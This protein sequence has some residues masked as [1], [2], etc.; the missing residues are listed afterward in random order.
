MN[1]LSFDDKMLELINWIFARHE[2]HLP[3]STILLLHEHEED[4]RQFSR[5]TDIFGIR[6]RLGYYPEGSLLAD[7]AI[8]LLEVLNRKH[9]QESFWRNKE[10]EMLYLMAFGHNDVVCRNLLATKYYCG[11]TSQTFEKAS[12]YGHMPTIEIMLSKFNGYEDLVRNLHWGLKGAI[13]GKQIKVLRLYLNLGAEV[14]KDHISRALEFK[15]NV[16]IFRHLIDF[17]L[18][19]KLIHKTIIIAAGCLEGL[20]K[21]YCLTFF[22][23]LF[24][25]YNERPGDKLLNLKK[26]TERA[27]RREYPK[28]VKYL[29]KRSNS[30][31]TD[32]GI[33]KNGENILDKLQNLAK[34]LE[35]WNHDTRLVK[36]LSTIE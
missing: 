19:R 4:C 29:L 7:N 10:Y 1:I 11:V 9:R 25:M 33:K 35:F 27:F 23:Y 13:D 18:T 21:R 31:R 16:L 28:T 2:Y 20:E 8:E 26:A 15:E 5:L 6:R 34:T 22:N 17:L 3:M 24:K 14:K 12:Y 32:D 36:F 30:D